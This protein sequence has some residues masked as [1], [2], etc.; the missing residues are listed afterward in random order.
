M[1][2][3]MSSTARTTATWREKNPRFTGKC[4]T[5]FVASRTGPAIVASPSS[6]HGSRQPAAARLS[7]RDPELGRRLRAAAV[8]DLGAP[9]VERAARRGRRRIR[10]LAVDRGEAFATVT[11]PRNGLEERLRVGV[12]RRVVNLLDRAGLDH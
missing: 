9:R 12:R 10:R 7:V 1:E 8:H 11:E 6:R 3:E 2:K 4:L 5:R